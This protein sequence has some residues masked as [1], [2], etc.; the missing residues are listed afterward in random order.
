[1]KRITMLLGAGILMFCSMVYAAVPQ[2]INFQGVLKTPADTAVSD[3]S[4]SV[5]FTIYDAPSG[6]NVLWMETQSVNTI[7][8]LF[9]VLLGSTT[10]V[11]D[12]IFNDSSRYLGITISADPEMTPRQRL[13]S[14]GYSHNS[15]EWTSAGQNLFRLNGNVGIGTA[16]PA[17]KLDIR[18]NFGADFLRFETSTPGPISF[19]LHTST[20][21]WALVNGFA[22]QDRLSVFDETASSERLVIDGPTG[23]VGIGTSTPGE[24]LEVNGA[25]KFTG[26][27]NVMS[28][29]PRVIRTDD[30]RP[31]CPP[32]WPAGTDMVVQSFSLTRPG[33]V[34]ITGD[35]VR[36]TNGRADLWLRV[37]GV[38]VQYTIAHTSVADWQGASVHWS[39]ALAAGAHTVSV[40]GSPANVWGCGS[41]WGGINTIIF[42]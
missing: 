28:R 20:R 35:M 1:M 41:T 15:S 30:T 29:A 34:F 36:I 27:A 18:T 21:R 33:M 4:Y 8:G 11:L 38:D 7:D 31:F 40:Q 24:K 16:S 2:L 22:F 32:T 39:G 19:L 6:G 13:S 23:N 25:L 10:P 14:V 26:D 3:G 9:T 12:S 5:T 42:E 37:D 17:G